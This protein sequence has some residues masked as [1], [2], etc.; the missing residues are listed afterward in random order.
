MYFIKVLLVIYK[1]L[2]I[3]TPLFAGRFSIT[4][5]ILHISTNRLVFKLCLYINFKKKKLFF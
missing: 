5:M 3:F 2:N 1:Y 4:V